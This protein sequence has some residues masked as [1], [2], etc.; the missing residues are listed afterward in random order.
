MP[1]TFIVLQTV[2][3]FQ[4]GQKKKFDPRFLEKLASFQGNNKEYIDKWKKKKKD[5]QVLSTPRTMQSPIDTENP[6]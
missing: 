3:L 1:L 6:K 2:I 5:V 4:R